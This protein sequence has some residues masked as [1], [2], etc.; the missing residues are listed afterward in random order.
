MRNIFNFIGRVIFVLVIIEFFKA[1]WNSGFIGK[2]I[3][4]SMLAVGLYHYMNQ[5]VNILNH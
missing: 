5:P 3:L 1:V 4:L 2:L